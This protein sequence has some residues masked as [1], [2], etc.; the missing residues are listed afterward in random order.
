MEKRKMIFGA[1]DTARDGLWTLGPWS[2]PEPE[3]KLNMV[4]VPGRIDG[5][6]DMSTVLTDGEPRFGSRTLT[7]ALQSSEGNRLEREARI[8]AMVNQLNGRQVD[9][10]LPD[11]PTR[12]ITGR[13]NVKKD[14]NDMAH[15]A[16]KVTATC[17]PWRYNIKPTSIE[18]TASKDIQLT[19]LSNA[20]A[21]TVVPEVTVSGNGA[22]VVLA[23]GSHTWELTP[24][25]YRLIDLAVQPGSTPLRYSGKGTVRIT[26]REAVQ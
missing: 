24:G 8:S 1:Y 21:R 2:F 17:A 12:Y 15:A 7:V 3:P 10:I 26:Y 18:L 6:L 5:P 22:R 11:D 25:S 14:Y 9:I 16:I 23:A 4:D 19:V 13:V 20:G